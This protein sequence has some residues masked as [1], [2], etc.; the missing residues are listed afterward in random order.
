MFF[1][2]NNEFDDIAKEENDIL[3]KYFI[4]HNVFVHTAHNDFDDAKQTFMLFFV[5]VFSN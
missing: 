2:F 5:L 4:V 1:R 3:L